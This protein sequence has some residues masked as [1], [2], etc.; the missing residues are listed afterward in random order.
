VKFSPQAV[1]VRITQAFDPMTGSGAAFGRTAG[2][3]AYFSRHVD[4]RI[5]RRFLSD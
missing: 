3:A 4:A 5:G 2:A 1:D